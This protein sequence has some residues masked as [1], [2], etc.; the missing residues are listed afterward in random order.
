M[1]S[2]VRERTQGIKPVYVDMSDF[3]AVESAFAEH[4][5]KMVWV[6]SPTNPTL[7]ISD[8]AKIAKIA[9]DHGAIAVTDNTFCSPVL[10]RPLDLGMHVDVIRHHELKLLNFKRI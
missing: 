3:S 5:P 4:K 7:K 1:M 2:L 8:L 10:Q 6:E 9:D